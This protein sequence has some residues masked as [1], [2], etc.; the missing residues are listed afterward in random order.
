LDGI[1]AFYKSPAGK[2]MLEKGPSLNQRT[3]D[4]LQSLQAHAKPLTDQATKDMKDKAQA[5]Y[6]PGSKSTTPPT[7]S[8][9]LSPKPSTSSSAS[10]GTPGSKN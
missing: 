5:L 10:F 7:Q 4:T 2:A 8:S 1:I 6:P 3:Y 9:T